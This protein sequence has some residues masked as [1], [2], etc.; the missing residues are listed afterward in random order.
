ML[1]KYDGM[2]RK[3]PDEAASLQRRRINGYFEP[4]KYKQLLGQAFVDEDA[5]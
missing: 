4:K 1:M 3:D 2:H 5:A